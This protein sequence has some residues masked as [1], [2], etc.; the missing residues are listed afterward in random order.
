MEAKAVMT[1]AI[2]ML[3]GNAPSAK[4]NAKVEGSTS[5][6][7]ILDK[8]TAGKDSSS[9]LKTA[10]DDA[11]AEKN[12]FQVAER[13]VENT[14]LPKGEVD[15]MNVDSSIQETEVPGVTEDAMEAVSEEIVQV[16]KDALLMTDEEMEALMAQMGITGL[17]LLDV[18]TLQQ[19]VLK[20]TDHTDVSEMLTDEGLADTFQNLITQLEELDIP[21]SLGITREQLT[22][23]VQ[24]AVEKGPE[25]F[26]EL[27]ARAA[28]DAG[29]SNEAE[30]EMLKGKGSEEEPVVI[31]QN[32]VEDGD[33]ET[34]VIKNPSMQEKTAD[35][36]SGQSGL[37]G[38]GHQEKQQDGDKVSPWQSFTQGLV[39]AAG[40]T[41][42]TQSSGR[43]VQMIDIVNQIIEQVKV[44]LTR[45]TTSMEIQLNPESL[46][47]VNLTVSAKEGVMV[48]N[49]AVQT[50]MAKEALESQMHVLKEQ[51]DQ[52][53]IKVEAVEV[54]VTDFA[55]AQ[56][57]Q[58]EGGNQSEQQKKAKGKTISID[59]LQ[60]EM[61]ADEEEADAE[62]P[63][64]IGSGG[65]I[66]YT[67]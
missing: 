36:E 64:A 30:A 43:M 57:D 12:V 51:F 28:T 15:T 10:R 2:T 35:S 39:Q 67:V 53:G 40:E 31:Q 41:T 45:E 48:A 34:V 56:S 49:F 63:V 32:A 9:Q 55:F 20:A 19:F 62:T 14:K 6:G 60:K 18:S 37:P 13:P 47:K 4:A 27:F 66:D 54:T 16:V 42:A 61:E 26:G 24:E 38:G 59:E 17:A 5:F 50:E 46:G 58:T 44:N 33:S 8:S 25:A 1:K 65:N 3:A 23:L 21:D 22:E 7:S 11:P 52:K 29:V